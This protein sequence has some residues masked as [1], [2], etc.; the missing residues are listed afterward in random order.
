MHKLNVQLEIQSVDGHFL[1]FSQILLLN[2][3]PVLLNFALEDCMFSL[4]Q[5]FHHCAWLY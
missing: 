5:K 1:L 3:F 2:F 4:H